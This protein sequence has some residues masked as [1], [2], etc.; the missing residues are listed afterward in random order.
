MW[1]DVV[2]QLCGAWLAM[3]WPFPVRDSCYW[4]WCCFVRTI[5]NLMWVAQR[6]CFHHCI[7]R[8]QPTGSSGDT[9]VFF[10]FFDFA[11]IPWNC[12]GILDLPDCQRHVGLPLHQRLLFLMGDG[13]FTQNFSAGY[14]ITTYESKGKKTGVVANCLLFLEI[15][16]Y[17]Y[18]YIHIYIYTYIYIYIH[19]Y[20]Y[21]LYFNYYYI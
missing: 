2:N 12:K 16:T 20:T 11:A 21:I 4:W 14:G 7:N 10:I 6:N 18:I 17:I 13:K 3:G 1:A 5:I 15:Y 19:I 9:I 8:N